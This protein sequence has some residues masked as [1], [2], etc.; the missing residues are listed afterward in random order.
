MEQGIVGMC[1]DEKRQILIPAELGY[2]NQ[3]V[4]DYRLGY[5][6]ANSDLKIEVTLVEFFDDEL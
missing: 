2:G 3:V 1:L 4:D 6:P 5:I